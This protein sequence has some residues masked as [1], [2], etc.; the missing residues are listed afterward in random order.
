MR[1][2][3][4]LRGIGESLGARYVPLSLLV[5]S[6]GVIDQADG[7]AALL[8]LI[9]GAVNI[10]QLVLIDRYVQRIGRIFG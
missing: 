5:S 2:A 7:N 9:N 10:L 4:V 3:T 1:D 8:S 6:F